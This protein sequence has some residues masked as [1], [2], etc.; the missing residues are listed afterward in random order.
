MERYELTA[1]QAFG[2]L[3]RYSQHRNQRLRDVARHVIE[4]GGLPR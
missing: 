3:Q 4:T 1:V 2:V